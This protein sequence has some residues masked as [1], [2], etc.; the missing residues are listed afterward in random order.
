[1]NQNQMIL[2]HLKKHKVIT[3]AEAYGKYGVYR[4][5]ARIL[6]LRD[7]G[8]NIL[9]TI[10]ESTGRRGTKHFAEY[11]LVKAAKVAV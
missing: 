2:Q 7:A 11:R 8:H 5:S 3:P 1:M 6:D 9:T 4:L 10:V